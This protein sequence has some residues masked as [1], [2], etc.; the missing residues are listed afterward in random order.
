MKAAVYR[1]DFLLALGA[2]LALPRPSRGAGERVPSLL[3]HIVLGFNDLE[4]G[5]GF[6]SARTGV[7]PI[8]GGVHPG[9]GTR[10]AVLN[11][12]ERQYLEIL[13]PDP[14]QAPNADPYNLRALAAPR[15]L[16]W[17]VHTNNVEETAKRIRVGG[18]EA[19]DARAGSR[20]RPDGQLLS[21]RI[22]LLKDDM[23]GLL[24]FFVEWGA[25]SAHPSIDAPRGCYLKTFEICAPDRDGMRHRLE[26]LGLDIP[27]KAGS[28]PQFRVVISGPRGSLEVSSLGRA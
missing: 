23:H 3:D 2:A 16:G 11:L 27:V 22:V 25:T 28:T 4:A 19:L 12:G 17:A 24:P 18:M 20:R 14:A 6:V 15:L 5:I 26:I 1:R 9:G 7:R 8:F 13:A 10:N 21:W